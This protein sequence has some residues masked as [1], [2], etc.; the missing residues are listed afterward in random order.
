MA[1]KRRKDEGHGRTAP[2]GGADGRAVRKDGRV[3]TTQL[4][5][6]ELA[7]ELAA[8]AGYL[9]R[10]RSE[11]VADALAAYLPRFAALKGLRREVEAEAATGRGEAPGDA[12]AASAGA[13]EG[14]AVE[15]S[16]HL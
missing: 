15:V 14:A 16:R 4:L 2:A 13:G 6:P 1:P 11:V 5:P 8:L 10:E 9:G 3:K 12:E 7:R